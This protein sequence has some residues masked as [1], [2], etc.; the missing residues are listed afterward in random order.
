MAVQVGVLRRFRRFASRAGEKARP[1]PPGGGTVTTMH[2]CVAR[3][4]S[5]S[6]RRIFTSISASLSCVTRAP[7]WM[8]AAVARRKGQNDSADAS[9]SRIDSGSCR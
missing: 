8:F 3:C 2:S 1:S 4:Y 6:Q 7:S 5:R 9:V